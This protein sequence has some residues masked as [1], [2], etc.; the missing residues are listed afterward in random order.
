MR[1]LFLCLSALALAGCGGSTA[2]VD[3]ADPC[4][5]PVLIPERWLSDREVEVLWSRDRHELLDC[6]GKVETLSGRARILKGHPANP[7]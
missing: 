1:I 2:S 7:R 3:S 5:A 4:A 6:G